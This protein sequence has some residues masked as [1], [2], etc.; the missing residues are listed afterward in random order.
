[1]SF[2]GQKFY[3]PCTFLKLYLYGYHISNS[4]RLEAETYRNIEVKWL[5]CDLHTDFKTIAD[6]RK[7][8]KDFN[9]KK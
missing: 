8:N 9:A 5:L 3:S 6:F 4:R 1:M 2:S 7:D